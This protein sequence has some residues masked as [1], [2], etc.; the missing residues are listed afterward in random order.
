MP[1]FK[2]FKVEVLALYEAKK[3][4]NELDDLL[5]NPSPANLRDY[6]LIKLSEEP[7]P[8]D[9]E[10]FQ[11]FFN[12]FKKKENIEVAIKTF[13]TGSLRALQKFILGQTQ[14]PD[15]LLVKLLSILVDY[16]PR[17]F[18]YGKENTQTKPEE[19]DD[20]GIRAVEGDQ[21]DE[22]DLRSEETNQEGSEISIIEDF[23]KEEEET[24]GNSSGGDIP[25]PK[26]PET[27]DIDL[28]DEENRS[29]KKRKVALGGLTIV[30]ITSFVGLIYPKKNCMC[31]DGDKFV[32][33]YCQDK[34]QRNQIVGL[35]KDKLAFFRRITQPDT[36]GLKDVGHVWYSKIDNEVEFFTQPG[37]HPIK[38]DR[39]LKI[40]TE[41]IIEN[42]A[43]PKKKATKQIIETLADVE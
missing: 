23:S 16:Q 36:L 41:H 14:K 25:K 5:A 40:A 21:K 28:L 37:L 9:I 12:P 7:P 24:K 10:V 20:K 38:V 2:D 31:W 4:R 27:G 18:Q 43:G 17:P 15:D 34:T 1:E 39:S 26:D 33:V 29:T 32:A 13:N 11:K 35:D 19:L 30:I 8:T 42:H 6:C 3:S 22:D